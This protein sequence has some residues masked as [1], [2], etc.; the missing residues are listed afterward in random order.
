MQQDAYFYSDPFQQIVTRQAA[1]NTDKEFLT[2]I[3]PNPHP[4]DNPTASILRD[5]YSTLET[6]QHLKPESQS[7]ESDLIRTADRIESESL[8]QCVDVIAA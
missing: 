3:F 5:V 1:Y 6:L 2:T 7:E 8:Q 4:L